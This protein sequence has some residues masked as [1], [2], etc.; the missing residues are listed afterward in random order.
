VG[1]LDTVRQA[2]ALLREEGRVS[3]RAL[4][5]EFGLDDQHLDDL[6]EELV[7]V[8]RVATRD[9]DV[10]VA[11]SRPE[12]STGAPPH[13][14][15]LRLAALQ[16]GSADTDRRDLTVL[17]C[18]LV[19]S[20][21]LSTRLD[22]EDYGEALRV[23]H[24]AATDVV[25]RC[26]GFVAQLLGDGMVV[27]FGYPEAQ[28]DSADQAVRAG[29]EIVRVVDALGRGLSVRVGVHSGPCVI[30]TVGA[31]GR[32]D[33]VALGETPN[34]AARVQAAAE[35][36]E[37]IISAATHRLV[38]GWFVVED[39]GARA[40]K[41]VPQPILVHRVL[42]PS[43]V[44]S[45]LEARSTGGLAPLVG[46]DRECRLLFDGW[47]T[48]VRGVGQVVHL[49][50]EPGIGKSRL[51]F[52]MHEHLAGQPHRW[53]AGSCTRYVRNTAFHPIVEMVEQSLGFEPDDQPADRV[54]RVEEGLRAAGLTT[55]EQLAL[56]TS[57]LAIPHPSWS[58]LRGLSPE[59]R[60]Q[61]TIDGLVEWLVALSER[62]PVVLLVEDLHWCDPSSLELLGRV[63]ERIAT[64]RVLL[65]TTSRPDFV[66]AWAS[67]DHV[68][69]VSLDRVTEL[70]ATELVNAMVARSALDDGVRQR[71]VERADG[72][73]LF[74]EELSQMVL[75]ASD[76]ATV[77]D[78]AALDIPSTLQ[79]S[80]LAR[81][82]RLGEARAFAQVAAVI[83][84]EFSRKMVQLVVM[85]AQIGLDDDALDDALVQL[86][87]TGLVVRSGTRSESYTFKHALVQDAASHSLLRATRSHLHRSVVHVLREHFPN[88]IDVQPE[89][90]ARHAEAG[91]MVDDA[92]AWYEQASEQARARSEHEE[93]LLHLH[94][95]LDLLATGAE[96][97]ERDQR[98]IALQQ[99]LAVEL[100]VARGYS[101]S[102]AIA[103]LERVRELAQ[104]CDDTRSHAG[105]V[106][107]LGLAAYTSTD[108]ERGETLVVE[109][110]AIAERAG[111]VAHMVA[112]LGTYALIVF[113][114]G[115]FRE[116]LELAERAVELYEP[117]QHHRDIVSIVGDDTGVS[118]LATSGWGLL[119]LGFPDQAMARCDDAV[120]L[121]NSLDTPYSVAQA[122]VWRVA[123]LNDRRAET[124]ADA[125]TDAR[126]FCDEQ[127]FPAMSGGAT[128]FLG[129]ALNDLDVLLEGTGVLASTGTLLMAPSACMWVADAN[130]AQGLYD[131]AFAMIDAGLDLGVSTRQRYY[132]S[133]LHRVKAE[134]ILA[135][136]RQSG[137]RRAEAA[138]DEFRRAVE[139]AK[140]QESKWFELRATIGLARLLLSEQRRNEARECLRPIF[141]SFTEGFDLRDL[142]D[143]RALLAEIGT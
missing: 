28:E 12:T 120:R 122:L 41:G 3:E 21:E 71:I 91:G 121:A 53:L 105:A 61:R 58:A 49:C 42:R 123:L 24:E 66:P 119:H 56:I 20:T 72:N 78:P 45:R 33:T 94:R 6:V 87:D 77:R 142:R 139:I 55:E 81:L 113:F 98:E 127:G 114:Q 52:V 32:R 102:E 62:D 25:T 97:I 110:Y 22:S 93:A 132:D 103:A 64:E 69:D 134:I 124:M 101:V 137:D 118:A 38:A 89:L 35:P 65:V 19:G 9:G 37:V 129:L 75:E 86:T 116:A 107:G 126:R 31:G 26:G 131:D 11:V 23:Y 4:R 83:G 30:R 18:D 7:E 128:A 133:P 2:A 54:R 106:I 135:D 5:R 60:R 82:D 27:L 39:A 8:R 76:H 63:V 47:D 85:D 109:G 99:T 50:G 100:F 16:P 29:L 36:G 73:P 57:F 138:E 59:A 10:L 143:A 90:A 67:L 136:N 80:L 40:M 92:I 43:A 88:R 84:R 46:R 1:F 17:F 79:S 112:A 95:A 111:A 13:E 70:E 68:H 96:R 74:L 51:A 140:A 108:F 15:S 34:I 14:P 141:S 117:A 130:R 125:A 115:R 48:A 44:R 104:A